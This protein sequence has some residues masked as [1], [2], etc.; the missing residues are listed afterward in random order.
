MQA[1]VDLGA[2]PGAWTEHLAKRAQRVAAVDPAA[3]S[4]QCTALPNVRHIRKTSAATAEIAAACG[5]HK[6]SVITCD[7][8]QTADFCAGCIAPLLPLLQPGGWV[9]MTVKLSGRAR[10]R[11]VDGTLPL[12]GVSGGACLCFCLNLH[13]KYAAQLRCQL[14]CQDAALPSSFFWLCRVVADA[15]QLVCWRASVAYYAT[16]HILSLSF[17]L[18]LRLGCSRPGTVCRQKVEA[19]LRALPAWRGLRPED[20]R[21]V[22]L[23]ANTQHERTWLV[24]KPP[25]AEE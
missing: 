25:A 3:L 24:Q 21:L 4:A 19:W 11:C 12:L 23:L 2:S 6:A 16:L 13:T 5:G 14:S 10:D 22:W 1:A 20:G 8:N 7:M 18:S 17:G 9:I 15:N